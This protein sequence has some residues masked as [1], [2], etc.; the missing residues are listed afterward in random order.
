M[1]ENISE[2]HC[3]FHFIPLIW[4]TFFWKLLYYYLIDIILVFYWV[5]II[6]EVPHYIVG[7]EKF[8]KPQKLSNESAK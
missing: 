6:F 5:G 2:T 4:I 8:E 7:D 1:S 3:L